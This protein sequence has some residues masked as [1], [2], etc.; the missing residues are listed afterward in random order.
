MSGRWL[1]SGTGCTRLKFE[2]SQV[3]VPAAIHARAGAG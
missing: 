3:S 1:H 2:V